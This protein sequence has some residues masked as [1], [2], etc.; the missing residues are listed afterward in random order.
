LLQFLDYS[1]VMEPWVMV[2]S[3]R[4]P[5]WMGGAVSIVHSD[6]VSG[7]S[8]LVAAMVQDPLDSILAIFGIDWHPVLL[9]AIGGFLAAEESHDP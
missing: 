6:G 9:L 4:S 3:S 8:I 2:S 5:P 1:V 7:R